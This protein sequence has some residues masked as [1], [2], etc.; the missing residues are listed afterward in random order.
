MDY[1]KFHRTNAIINLTGNA[2]AA[3]WAIVNLFLAEYFV[4]GP[5]LP[6]FIAFILRNTHD[7]MLP[8]ENGYERESY[9][10]SLKIRFSDNRRLYIF[11]IIFFCVALG[12]VFIEVYFLKYVLF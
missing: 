6:I 2:I 5:F 8:L 12:L 10:K 4:V 7:I 11:S 9:Y 1:K 3:A